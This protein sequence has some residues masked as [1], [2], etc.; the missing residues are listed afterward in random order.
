[1]KKV[2]IMIAASM[3]M[4]CANG[5][6]AE[7]VHV[8]AAASLSDALGDIEEMYEEEEHVE[9]IMNYGSSGQLRQQIVQGAPVDVF[10][11]AAE[12]DMEMLVDLGEVSQTTALLRN[13]L[14]LISTLEMEIADWSD[15]T[16]VDFQ[17]IAVGHP[18]SVPAGKYA[19]QVLE[20]MNLHTEL[21]DQFVYGQDVRQVL[22]YVETGNADVGIVY[23]TD[24]LSTEA[25]NRLHSHRKIA[26]TDR[27]SDRSNRGC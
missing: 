10:I 24:A 2:W 4:A 19:A 13:R 8:M 16:T 15:L 25:S 14:Q 6:E 9:L 27:L 5:E 11:S 21:E 26:R 17:R 20:T 7:Q 12:S 18:E 1:M 22:T 3:L 23:Q